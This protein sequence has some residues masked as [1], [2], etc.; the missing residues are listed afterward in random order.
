MS[1]AFQYETRPIGW[2]IPTAMQLIPPLI[3]AIGLPFTPGMCLYCML[4]EV[5]ESPRWLV[6]QGKNDLALEA[7]NKLRSHEEVESGMTSQEVVAFDQAIEED[8]LL[9]NGGW[10]D[11][12]RGTYRRRTFVNIQHNFASMMY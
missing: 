9:Q 2:L 6:L 3:L 12:M 7:L 5:V 11:L 10:L 4:A 8:K 1:R